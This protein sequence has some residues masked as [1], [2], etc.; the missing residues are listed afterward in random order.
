[1]FVLA[2]R[3]RTS[4]VTSVTAPRLKHCDNAAKSCRW[5]ISRSRT[6]RVAAKCSC[7]TAMWAT[8][9]RYSSSRKNEMENSFTLSTKKADE[10]RESVFSPKQR[11]IPIQQ[12]YVYWRYSPLCRQTKTEPT[13][14][15]LLCENNLDHKS[16]LSACRLWELYMF[17]VTPFCV[18]Q[19][20]LEVRIASY[21]RI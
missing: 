10:E 18:C 15:V 2:W 17:C 9:G 8:H 3:C 7:S 4:R 5:S 21:R 12:P 20:I 16:S 14:P 1:M 13:G 19:S 11:I 6:G